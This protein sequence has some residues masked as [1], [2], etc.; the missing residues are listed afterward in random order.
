MSGEL[1]F[2]R[3]MKGAAAVGAL[4]IC[5]ALIA[6]MMS[7]GCPVVEYSPSVMFALFVALLVLFVYS[8]FELARRGILSVEVMRVRF[9]FAMA[10]LAE[11]FMIGL[12]VARNLECDSFVRAI[13]IPGALLVF[14][15]AAAFSIVFSDFYLGA[16]RKIIRLGA[17]P[18][19]FLTDK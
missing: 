14:Y 13:P 10:F 9:A 8:K 18:R 7:M 1:I 2:I 12:L 17:R 3:C 6:S 5:C 15:T 4:A 16:A 19:N 11:M